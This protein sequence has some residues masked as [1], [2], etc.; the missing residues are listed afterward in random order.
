MHLALKP[1][2][3]SVLHTSIEFVYKWIDWV[4]STS[5][6]VPLIALDKKLESRVV[7]M[8]A[9]SGAVVGRKD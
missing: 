3:N 9:V 1:P 7:H 4:C 6:S 5:V 8:L 2:A